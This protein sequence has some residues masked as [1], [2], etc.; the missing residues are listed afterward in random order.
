MAIGGERH[1][2]FELDR[3]GRQFRHG[4]QHGVDQRG[5]QGADGD[6]DRGLGAWITNGNGD[7]SAGKVVTLTLSMSESVTVSGGQ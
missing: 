5:H 2:H 4:E 6:L 3:C 1:R 7:L